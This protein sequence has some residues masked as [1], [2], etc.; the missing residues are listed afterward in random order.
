[1]A[2]RDHKNDVLT[3]NHYSIKEIEEWHSVQ[4]VKPRTKMT[5]MWTSL[6]LHYKVLKIDPKGS[7]RILWKEIT[8]VWSKETWIF[9]VSQI[10]RNY[11]LDPII[12]TGD[13]YKK[14]PVEF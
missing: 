6:S 2:R 9:H 12:S 14:K 1:M 11:S 3:F 8:P 10:E 5:K 7:G 4:L 13:S